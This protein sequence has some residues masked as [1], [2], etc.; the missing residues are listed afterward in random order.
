M[1]WFRQA[2]SHYPSQWWQI[3]VAILRHNVLS[4]CHNINADSRTTKPFVRENHRWQVVLTKNQCCGPFVFVL[5]LAWI[6]RWT[7][8][9]VARGW[10]HYDANV[11]SLYCLLVIF[12]NVAGPNGTI[13]KML[14]ALQRKLHW[15][16]R[17]SI[18]PYKDGKLF[19]INLSCA[20]SADN[21]ST[22]S[23]RPSTNLMSTM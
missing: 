2:A 16:S 22:E 20:L 19:M 11:I 9:R 17:I 14:I 5:L 10:R 21:Q 8:S 18:L 7:N 23:T 12:L 1:V 15:L 6:I 13:W 3:Y 4:N